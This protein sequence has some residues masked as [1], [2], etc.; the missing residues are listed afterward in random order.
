MHGKVC[1]SSSVKNTLATQH[2]VVC[3]PCTCEKHTYIHI[4]EY[5]VCVHIHMCVYSGWNLHREILILL[6]ATASPTQG[7]P[8]VRYKSNCLGFE[9]I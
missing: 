8:S 1:A 9:G 6:I 4:Y 5:V 2:G 7:K 3:F